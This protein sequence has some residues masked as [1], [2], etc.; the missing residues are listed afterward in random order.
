MGTRHRASVVV[1]VVICVLVLAVMVLGALETM[2]WSPL[3]MTDPQY[4]LGRIHA[5]VGPVTVVGT[6][7][8]L[9]VWAAF[10]IGLT[11]AAGLLMLQP[12]RPAPPLAVIAVGATLLLLG[13][14]ARFW[15]DFGMGNTVSDEVP[16]FRGLQSPVGELLYGFGAAM[17][18]VLAVVGIVAVVRALLRRRAAG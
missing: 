1:Y 11:T 13:S 3:A 17:L 14:F 8:S 2:V 18:P 9:W 16:P 10:G 4:D 6:V 7:I 12:R 15:A 5:I